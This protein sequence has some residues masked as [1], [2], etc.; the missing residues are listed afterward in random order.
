MDF[1]TFL[2]FLFFDIFV[3]FLVLF[4]IV[5]FGARLIKWIKEGCPDE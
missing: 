4:F 1:L 3:G 2:L 5:F